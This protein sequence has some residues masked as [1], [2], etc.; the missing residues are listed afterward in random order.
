M[1]EARKRALKVCI[2]RA[3]ERNTDGRVSNARGKRTKSSLSWVVA[4]RRPSRSRGAVSPSVPRCMGASADC[5]DESA[6]VMTQ[7]RQRLLAS[8]K[9]MLASSKPLAMLPARPRR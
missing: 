9:A 5:R 1:T 4:D 2:T 8:L 3:D 7:S 6:E